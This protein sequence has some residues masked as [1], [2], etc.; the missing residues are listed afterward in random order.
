MPV[1]WSPTA[2]ARNYAR[3][4]ERDGLAAPADF[5]VLLDEAE[6]IY[7][8]LDGLAGAR[9]FCHN[10]LQPQN[11][12]D[13][14]DRLWLIDWEWAGMGNRYFDLG[15]IAVNCDLDQ[16]ELDKLLRAYF[17]P[18]ANLELLRARVELMRVVSGV[19]EA[20]WAVVAE[21][22]LG[23]DWDYAAW[24]RQFFERARTVL[25]APT[26]A[27]LLSLASESA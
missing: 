12:I 5:E 27:D 10:D 2:D 23:N 1:S 22:L 9:G 15:G 25:H 21:Q 20:T 3:I 8:T 16:G 11:F 19:R 24:A 13:D 18:N 6:R 17:G 14:G 4:I 7:T 26:Y